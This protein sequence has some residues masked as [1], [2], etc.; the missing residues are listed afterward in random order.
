MNPEDP[1]SP[2]LIAARI[3]S[4]S[5][6]INLRVEL[7][8]L[9]YYENKLAKLSLRGWL[10]P[11]KVEKLARRLGLEPKLLFLKLSEALSELD[12]LRGDLNG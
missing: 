7:A 3:E 2:C 10:K 4:S 12:C 9:I 11:E 8:F 1:H 6:Y 5:G